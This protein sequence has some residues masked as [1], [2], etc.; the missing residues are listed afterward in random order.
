MTLFSTPDVASD[1]VPPEYFLPS[2]AGGR[3]SPARSQQRDDISNSI[4]SERVHEGRGAR[5][6]LLPYSR[7]FPTEERATEKRGC[8]SPRSFL[9]NIQRQPLSR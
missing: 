7:V 4:P 6:L 3:W 8:C 5:L 1:S 2:L 9:D